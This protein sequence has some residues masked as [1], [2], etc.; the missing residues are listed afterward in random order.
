[1]SFSQC[2]GALFRPH[3]IHH[4]FARGNTKRY[5]C[6]IDIDIVIGRTVAAVRRASCNFTKLAK[7]PP[8]AFRRVT[9]RCV[10]YRGHPLATSI[11]PQLTSSHRMP[12]CKTVDRSKKGRRDEYKKKKR[13]R[14]ARKKNRG[15]RAGGGKKDVVTGRR[16]KRGGEGREE[17]NRKD[18]EMER[19]A[20]HSV[21]CAN[22]Q[23]AGHHR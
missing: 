6:S 2:C 18:G 22:A 10:L 14:N 16:K 4:R 8:T 1:M 11:L 23:I 19:S 3:R 7:L 12:R 21:C 20:L 13:K 9:V 5:H 15:G 17:K